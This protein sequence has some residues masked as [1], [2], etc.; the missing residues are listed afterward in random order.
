MCNLTGRRGR[1]QLPL[2]KGSDAAGTGIMAH[3]HASMS[4]KPAAEASEGPLPEAA[5]E[6]DASA[7]DDED[8][9][10]KLMRLG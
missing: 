2:G 1:V 4:D 3:S 10:K 9:R 7:S 8:R 6:G 5:A